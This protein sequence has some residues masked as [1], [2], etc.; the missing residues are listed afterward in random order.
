MGLISV[1]YNRNKEVF[2]LSHTFVILCVSNDFVRDY[3]DF[4]III[5]NVIFLF[6]TFDLFIVHNNVDE[7]Y[8]RFKRCT[9]M[10][11][12]YPP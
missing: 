3:S 6:F 11:T 10:I 8:I 5:F 12:H 2:R 4:I 9:F 1:L 7:C